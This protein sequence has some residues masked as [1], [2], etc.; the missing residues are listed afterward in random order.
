MSLRGGNGSA[1]ML[2]KIRY[3]NIILLLNI[4]LYNLYIIIIII[5]FIFLYTVPLY[6]RLK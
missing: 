2:K 1:C 4:D 5:Y 3:N 6:R